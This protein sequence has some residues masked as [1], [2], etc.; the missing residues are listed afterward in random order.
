VR[1]TSTCE[2]IE[3]KVQGTV[4]VETWVL[5]FGD[6]AVVLEPPALPEAVAD[7]LSR[8]V[9][10]YRP[11]QIKAVLAADEDVSRVQKPPRFWERNRP[12]GGRCPVRPAP[13]PPQF[14]WASSAA[15]IPRGHP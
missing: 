13:L 6:K 9:G 5:G 14:V 8:A 1:L 7:E 2:T 15:P 4:E 10:S 3:L 12:S 11:A